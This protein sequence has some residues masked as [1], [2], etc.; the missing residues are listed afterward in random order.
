M[1]HK[2]RTKPQRQTGI[3]FPPVSLALCKPDFFQLY[4]RNPFCLKFCGKYCYSNPE[5]PA[6][7]GRRMLFF[8][9]PDIL[10]QSGSPRIGIRCSW[11]Q[12]YGEFHTCP[13]ALTDTVSVG[14]ITGKLCAVPPHSQHFLKQITDSALLKFILF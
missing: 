5:I 10:C 11:L 14:N 9:L 1:S 2:V 6:V 3:W 12:T 4:N 8:P 13:R 7:Y